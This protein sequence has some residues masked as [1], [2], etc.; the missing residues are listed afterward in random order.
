MN[1]TEPGK[2]KALNGIKEND[3]KQSLFQMLM[4]SIPGWLSIGRSRLSDEEIGVISGIE[5]FKGWVSD[6][7]A[8]IVVNRIN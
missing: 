7:L 6:D 8:I 1:F 2:N 3:L 5:S 4:Q